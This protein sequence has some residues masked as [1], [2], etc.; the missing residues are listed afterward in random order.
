MIVIPSFPRAGAISLAAAGLLLLAACGDW[1]KYWAEDQLVGPTPTPDETPPTVVVASPSGRDSDQAT[2]VGGSAYMIILNVIDDVGAVRVE[3]H[4]DDLPPIDILA[5]PWELAWD[6]TTLEEA[7]RHRIW[8]KAFDAAG[9]VG[10]SEAVF[11]QIFNEGPE[12]TIAAP[13]DGALILGTVEIVATFP[14][15]GP[16]IAQVEFLADVWTLDTVTAPP[17][18]VSWDT[19]TLPSGEHFLAAKATTVLGHVGVSSAVRVHVNNGAPTMTIDFP[20]ERVWWRSDRQ[21]AL[22]TGHE[23]WTTNLVAGSHVITATATNAWGTPTS[24]TL[25][26]EVL[27]EPT[28]RFCADIQWPIFEKYF[29][30]FCHDPRSSEYPNSELD[31]RSHESLMQGG[32]TTIYQCVY[33][34]RPE[35]SLVYNKITSLPPAVPWLGDYMPPPN[36]ANLPTVPEYLAERL[37]V[38]I[39]EGAPPD[40]PA[41]CQ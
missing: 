19:T 3:V 16:E 40:D 29:C 26:I 11:A 39:S 31:L 41:P 1:D 30:T 23:L 34:C 5:P 27:A 35:S 33:P 12:I 2:P 22:G 13:G 6:T 10:T 28:Y 38:W 8:A 17:W 32:R 24:A 21:G 9:N 37:R 4:I 14:G 36:S 7:S 18:T 20:P 25:D 15:E